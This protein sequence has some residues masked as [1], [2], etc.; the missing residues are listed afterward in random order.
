[1]LLLNRLSKMWV[2]QK[3][4]GSTGYV[5]YQGKLSLMKKMTERAI[6]K[7]FREACDENYSIHLSKSSAASGECFSYVMK[8]ET[9]IDGPWSNTDEPAT[10][11][12]KQIK[13]IID[14]KDFEWRPFQETIINSIASAKR[15]KS[16]SAINIV[17]DTKGCNGKTMVK[18]YCGVKKLAEIIPPIN[19]HKHILRLVM[20]TLKIGAYIV[21][22]P[23][24][25]K[26]YVKN[27]KLS[28]LFSAIETIKDGY[29]FDDRYEFQYEYF[30]SPEI[31]VFTPQ[32][33]NHD[34]LRSSKWK[35]WY[36]ND[37]LELAPII[38]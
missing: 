22:I 28:Q 13:E 32:C 18:T 30:D 16:D 29:A 24:G 12:P 34:S 33:P 14:E 2:F 38:Q 21:D 35:F 11:M 15:R 27:N 37:E 23:V 10:R 26:N 36:I 6:V 20:K 5:H 4:E 1:M 17:V 8:E 3:E 9:R 19:D 7:V 31:W 25:F